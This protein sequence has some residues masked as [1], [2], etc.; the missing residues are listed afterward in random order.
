VCRARIESAR[1]RAQRA[2][3]LLSTPDILWTSPRL[4]DGPLTLYI[5]HLNHGCMTTPTK[6][7][8]PDRERRILD[9]ASRLIVQYGYDKT[10]VSDIAEAAGISK[11][12]VYLHFESKETLFDALIRREFW[13]YADAY[14]KRLD[15]DPEGGTIAGIYKNTLYTMQDSPLMQALFRQDR[16]VLGAYT[17]RNQHLLQI[18]SIS[19]EQFIIWMQQMGAVRTDLTPKVTAYIMN[20][21][22]YALVSMDD[23]LPPDQIPPM[24]EVIEGIAVVLGAALTPP[25][26]PP[27]EALKTLMKQAI[28]AAKEVL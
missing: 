21:L 15:A 5:H 19:S 23:I 16:R 3:P 6:S 17:R 20:M 27:S 25:D 22:S 10:T 28:E 14:I 1:F 12:A 9:A 26:A 13:L 24:E 7:T 18:R 8:N 4:R 11:G 2:A